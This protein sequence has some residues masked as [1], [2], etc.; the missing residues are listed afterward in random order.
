[1]GRS[2]WSHWTME[3]WLGHHHKRKR[4]FQLFFF[5]GFIFFTIL[6]CHLL[7]SLEGVGLQ[8]FFAIALGNPF[9]REME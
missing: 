1:M 9:V 5:Y 2:A 6:L 8:K 4:I 7:D 3:R